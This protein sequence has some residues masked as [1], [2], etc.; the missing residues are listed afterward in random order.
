VKADVTGRVCPQG[1]LAYRSEAR[2][3]KTRH[4]ALRKPY[5]QTARL[6]VN[7]QG[8]L[9][10]YRSIIIRANNSNTQ[11]VPHSAQWRSTNRNQNISVP[12]PS[13]RIV[14][15]QWVFPLQ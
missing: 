5:P 7:I 6:R 2:N 8:G 4:T 1:P 11:D 10:S 3:S 13:K 12:L 15:R 9:T 14:Q